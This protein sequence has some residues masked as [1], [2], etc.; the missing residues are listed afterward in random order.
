M[1]DHLRFVLQFRTS[2]ATSGGLMTIDQESAE[3]GREFVMRVHRQDV[4]DTYW[5]GRTT[6]IAPLS[7]SMPHRSK[8]SVPFLGSG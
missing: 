4:F 7:R 5:S 1:S 3:E 6:T 8:M 2:V